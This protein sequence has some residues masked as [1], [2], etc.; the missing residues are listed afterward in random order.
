[1]RKAKIK[2]LL[3]SLKEKKRYVVYEIISESM[4]SPQQAFDAINYTAL[5]FLGELGY[6]NAGI[7]I[8]NDIWNQDMQRGIVKVSNKYTDQLRS[9]FMLVKSIGRQDVIV[10]SVGTSGTLKKAKNK[11]LSDKYQRNEV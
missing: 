9:A 6:G 11:Y 5:Q 3:P 2:S 8:M 1:M 4:I 10:R 7:R